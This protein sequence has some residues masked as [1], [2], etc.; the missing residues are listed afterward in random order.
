MAQVCSS[1][2][3]IVKAAFVDVTKLLIETA[4]HD[5]SSEELHSLLRCTT[6]S[7]SYI[8][9]LCDFYANHKEQLQESLQSIGNGLP[10]IIDV[11]WRLDYCIKVYIIF[12][13]KIK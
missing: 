7:K 8:D 2:S 12:I 10:H 9:K 5:T 1:K 3:D 11:D 13:N 4:R 6:L